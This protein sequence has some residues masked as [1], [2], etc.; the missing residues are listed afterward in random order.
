M[1]TDYYK[2]L[3]ISRNATQDAIR[4]AYLTRAKQYH[5]DVNNGKDANSEFQLIN[6]A[7]QTLINQDKRKWYDFK[8]KYPTTTGLS[9]GHRGAGAH[10]ERRHSYY[11]EQDLR[12]KQNSQ[13]KAEDKYIKTLFDKVLFYFL[14]F[15]GVFAI[16][17]GIVR[18]LNEKWEGINDLSGIIFGVWFVLLLLYG[19][20]ALSK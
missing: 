5:P 8:L 18:L 4:K 16:I 19:W 20:N 1:Q 10:A 13:Q 15:T 2:I 3:N 7:Y 12:K 11:S 6:E 17:F 9:S 14:I